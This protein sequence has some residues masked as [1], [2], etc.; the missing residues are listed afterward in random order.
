MFKVTSIGHLGLL[1]VMSAKIA[2][3]NLIIIV[4]GLGLVLEKEI[5][6]IKYLCF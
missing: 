6:G 2:L 1:I 5:I 4:R 3:K